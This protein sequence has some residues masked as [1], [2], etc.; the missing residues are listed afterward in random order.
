VL[1]KPLPALGSPD[2]PYYLPQVRYHH[3]V[4]KLAVRGTDRYFLVDLPTRTLQGPFFPAPP[5]GWAPEDA[6]DGRL[7]RLEVWEQYLVGWMAGAG[8]FVADLATGKIPTYVSPIAT[9]QTT[10]NA[11][12]TTLFLL[13]SALDTGLYHA[14]LT[15]FDPETGSPTLSVL[16]DQARSLVPN[17]PAGARNNRFLLL[18]T[19]AGH[20]QVPVAVDM[21]SGQAVNIPDSLANLPTQ[22]LLRW[23]KNSRSS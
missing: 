9:Y 16:F 13:P 5:A 2:F 14:V 10:R 7:C 12:P 11:P 22:A 20:G 23:L 3:V 21:A 17:L 6:A 8:T 15:G 19:G 18:R 4:G 1:V